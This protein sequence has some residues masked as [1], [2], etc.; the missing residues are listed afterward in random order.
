[1]LLGGPGDDWL[2]GGSGFDLCVGAAG[3]DTFHNCEKIGSRDDD[4]DDERDDD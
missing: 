1:L 3:Y 2:D 4:H